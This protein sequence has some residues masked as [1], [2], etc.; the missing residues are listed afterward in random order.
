MKDNKN[1]YWVWLSERCGAAS[2]DFGRLVAEHDDPY[3]IYSMGNEEIEQIK[4]IG[5]SIKEK[6]CN[7]VLEDPYSI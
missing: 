1:L 3:E 2:R 4:G 5:K 7:K 6:L